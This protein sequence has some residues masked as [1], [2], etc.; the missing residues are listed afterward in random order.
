MLQV[1]LPTAMLCQRAAQAL[2]GTSARP[3]LPRSGKAQQTVMRQVY[4][5]QIYSCFLVCNV[6]Q[7]TCM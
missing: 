5:V 6:M 2:K 4:E 3:L 7:S 1:K